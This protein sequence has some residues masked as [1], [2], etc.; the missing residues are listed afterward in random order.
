MKQLKMYRPPMEAPEVKLPEGWHIRSYQPGDGTDWCLCCRGGALGVDDE[1]SEAVFKEKMLDDPHVAAEDVLFIVDDEGFVGGTTTLYCRDEEN[2]GTVHM[3]AVKKEAQ[4]KGLSAPVVAAVLA[5]SLEKGREHITLTTDDFRVPAVK[6]YL[7]LGFIPVVGDMPMR[8]RWQALLRTLGYKTLPCVDTEYQPAEDIEPLFTAK[9]ESWTD[10]GHYYQDREAFAP[11]VEAIHALN[12]WE[13]PEAIEP[14]TPGTNFVVK[15]GDRVL[16]IYAP[17]SVGMTPDNEQK[18]EIARIEA[19][20]ARGVD[21]PAV[22]AK[23]IIR[24]KYDFYYM[25]MEFAAGQEAG[26]WMET[27]SWEEK[28]HFCQKMTGVL[29]ALHGATTRTDMEPLRQRALE[30]PRF[31][32]YGDEF[33]KEAAQRIGELM[34]GFGV[35]CHGDLTGENVLVDDDKVVLLDFADGCVA[36]FWY[37]WPPLF[38]DLLGGDG[39]LIAPFLLGMEL[40]YAAGLFADALLLHDFG[41]DILAKGM[42]P[43]MKRDKLPGTMK[44]LQELCAEYLVGAFNG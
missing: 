39:E 7:K 28:A 26:D 42:L 32:P 8:R 9:L 5:R 21:T 4:G 18:G 14:L 24:A 35:E 27:A 12:D 38:V 23:G 31:K 16:K 25:V 17:A 1:A 40:D 29:C 22:L 13:M 10:W 3:V 20:I 37:E 2:F 19:A 33:R 15:C 11:V 36:P 34:L 43:Q 44:E 6:T 41:P 30:N